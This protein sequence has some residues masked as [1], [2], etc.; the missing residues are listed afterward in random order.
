MIKAVF[1]QQKSINSNHDNNTEQSPSEVWTSV[2]IFPVF[3]RPIDEPELSELTIQYRSRKL[4][5]PS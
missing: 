2:Y 4:L 1:C 3:Y 5:K